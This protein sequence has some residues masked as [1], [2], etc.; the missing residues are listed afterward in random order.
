[1]PRNENLTPEQTQLLNEV[2]GRAGYDGSDCRDVLLAMPA[3]A[4]DKAAVAE[5]LGGPAA[6]AEFRTGTST[7]VHADM[8]R[9]D[10]DDDGDG[11]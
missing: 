8:S 2:T 7:T 6:A 10:I 1:V 5:V 3:P 4:A 9:S 11:M